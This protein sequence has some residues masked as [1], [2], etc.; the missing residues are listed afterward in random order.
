MSHLTLI[1]SFDPPIRKKGNSFKFQLW[2]SSALDIRTMESREF[3]QND[4]SAATVGMSTHDPDPSSVELELADVK[5]HAPGLGVVQSIPTQIVSETATSLLFD[6]C[7]SDRRLCD[8]GMFGGDTARDLVLD[9]SNA[10]KADLRDV[11]DGS[12]A[13]KFVNQCKRAKLQVITSGL[14]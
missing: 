3:S 11:P 14:F 6:G 1:W 5:P 2:V 10:M 4:L 9:E 13:P 8:G 7:M 12:L